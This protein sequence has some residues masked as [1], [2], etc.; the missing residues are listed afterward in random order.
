[1]RVDRI[2][3]RIGESAQN[4]PS[5]SCQHAVGQARHA[6][7]FVHDQR[8]ARQPRHQPAR[9]RGETTQAQHTARLAQAQY[10]SGLPHRAHQ[11]QRRS[12]QGQQ[13]FT[14][15]AAHLDR[16]ERDVGRRY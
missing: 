3:E 1:L 14:A 12:D 9:T 10:A 6:I 7:L 8:P 2:R 5:E 4:T 15:Q 16:V 13:P 11:L